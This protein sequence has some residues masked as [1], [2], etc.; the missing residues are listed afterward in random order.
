MNNATINHGINKFAIS[1]TRLEECSDGLEHENRFSLKISAATQA[2]NKT[3]NST[4]IATGLNSLHKFISHEV[5][6]IQP[7]P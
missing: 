5:S 3:S 7:L 4:R 6:I 1:R 2:K